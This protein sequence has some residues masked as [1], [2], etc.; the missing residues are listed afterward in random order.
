ML[1][2][3]RVFND[4]K[5]GLEDLEYVDILANVG[6]MDIGDPGIGWQE[7]RAWARGP[8]SNGFPE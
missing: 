6:P 2:F 4:K 7:W 1:C 3:A 8:K 5:V